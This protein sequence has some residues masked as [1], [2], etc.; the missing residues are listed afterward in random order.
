MTTPLELGIQTI[1]NHWFSA[2]KTL[3]ACQWKLFEVQY[4][5]G[6]KIAEAA[7]GGATAGKPGAGTTPDCRSDVSPPTAV[8]VQQLERRAAECISLGLAP[9]REIY[10]APH[11][12][13]IDWEKFPM[14]ARPSDP[15][16]FEGSC[17]EG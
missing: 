9:P 6:M 5:A 14:W 1:Y 7:L 2:A 11:R 3:L 8:D 13:Q 15:E 10:Q 16:L 4:Q 12:G 17:H